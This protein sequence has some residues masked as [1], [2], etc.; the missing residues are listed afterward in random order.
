MWH[1]SPAAEHYAELT[2]PPFP[3]AQKAVN[4]TRTT[5]SAVQSGPAKVVTTARAVSANAPQ[6]A[7]P[8]LAPPMT[9]LQRE[10]MF[11]LAVANSDAAATGGGDSVSMSKATKGIGKKRKQGVR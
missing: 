4:D 2:E 10:A 9:K 11:A 5:H 8:R 7:R 3:G 1:T 6:A